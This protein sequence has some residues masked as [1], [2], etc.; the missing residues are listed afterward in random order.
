MP[1]PTSRFNPELQAQKFDPQGL[2]IGEWAPDS[3]DREPIV[4]L[5][6]TRQAALAAYDAVKR[7]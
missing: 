1:R 2:Y 5:K 4:D 6:E 7:A 3:G